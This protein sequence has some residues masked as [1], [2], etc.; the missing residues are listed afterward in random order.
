MICSFFQ[1]VKINMNQLSSFSK[2]FYKQL[3]LSARSGGNWSK[4]LSQPTLPKP[5][6]LFL[7]VLQLSDEI[8]RSCQEN[9]FQ[10][11]ETFCV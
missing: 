11:L 3:S 6:P 5:T 8:L 9:K 4:F 2:C 7:A 10:D 1:A